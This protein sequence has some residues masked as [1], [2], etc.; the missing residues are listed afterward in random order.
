MMRPRR[1]V[2]VLVVDDSPLVRDMISHI[3]SSDPGLSIVGQAG[4]GLE[5]VAKVAALRP[6]IVTM[7]IEMPVLGGLAAIERIMAE[8]PVPI[9][10]VTSQTGVG[11]A[12]AA[13]SRGALDVVE[14]PDIDPANGAALIR[15]VKMLAGVDAAALHQAG[16]R[17][18]D[19][20]APSPAVSPQV[21][22]P[23]AG[24]RGKRL[25]AVACSTGG[26]KALNLI[27][28]GLP[29]DFPAPILVSQHV[30]L[31]FAP[32]LAEWLGTGTALKVGVA[33]SGDLL[34]PGRVYVN[35][36]EFTMRVTRRETIE[37]GGEAPGQIYHPS[38]DAM[39]ASVAE[40][41]GPQAVGV[42]LT[43]MG[44]DGVAGLKALKAAG[45]VTLA[46]DEESSV[47]FGMNG[48]AVNQGCVDKV[49]PLAEIP[50]QLKSLVRGVK[51]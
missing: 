49:L 16:K 25:V 45:G 30:C 38:C 20:P 47:I 1:P 8:N 33:R 14:K 36:P 48:V 24:S 18:G 34:E 19:R 15:K 9:L 23:T 7:D 43:G 39:L 31:G 32:G 6:D 27:L 44:D 35:P 3:L 11:T 12:F 21:F 28:S 41:Y 13:V 4:D 40:A 46:Q 42:I 5:A 10:V 50:G 51:P 26:P 22:G 17:P 37:L 2:R 29:G